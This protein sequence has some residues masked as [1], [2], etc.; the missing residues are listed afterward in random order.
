MQADDPSS[1][2]SSTFT[3]PAVALSPGTMRR[4]RRRR[5]NGRPDWSRMESLPDVMTMRPDKRDNIRIFTSQDTVVASPTTAGRN[6]F[7]PSFTK[8]DSRWKSNGGST[9]DQVP[10][11]PPTLRALISPSSRRRLRFLRNSNLM[12]QESNGSIELPFC[13]DSD[14]ITS[15]QIAKSSLNTKC[16]MKSAMEKK[17]EMNGK[18]ASNGWMY[19][20]PNLH[21]SLNAVDDSNESSGTSFTHSLT[22]LNSSSTILT[23]EASDASVPPLR[24]NRWHE[25]SSS[26]SADRSNDRP[27]L[28]P[29]SRPSISPT[30]ERFLRAQVSNDSL[31]QMPALTRYCDDD[32]DTADRS[33]CSS[34]R[35]VVSDD[36][37]T[38][39][40]SDQHSHSQFDNVSLADSPWMG[41]SN[42]SKASIATPPSP[43][44]KGE[45]TFRFET[46]N[47]NKMQSTGQDSIRKAICQP[48][49]SSYCDAETVKLV[50]INVMS[51]TPIHAESNGD[52]AL[53]PSP[54]SVLQDLYC[55]IASPLSMMS[56]QYLMS[57]PGKSR[58]KAAVSNGSTMDNESYSDVKA[59]T[60][61]KISPKKLK[62]AKRADTND[63]N[64][65][66]KLL[67][68]PAP[69]LIDYLPRTPPSSEKR[70]K[71]KVVIE[72]IA[73][74]SGVKTILEIMPSSASVTRAPKTMD[75]KEMRR[76]RGSVGVVVEKSKNDVNGA[77]FNGKQSHS[78][79][80]TTV[81]KS[82]RSGPEVVT[83]RL[84]KSPADTP[85]PA[86]SAVPVLGDTLQDSIGSMDLR[87]ASSGSLSLNDTHGQ[88]CMDRTGQAARR[89]SPYPEDD[90][91]VS[92][93][94]Q[95]RKK[96]KSRLTDRE[97]TKQRR[98][99]RG[100]T[101]TIET[102][103]KG[104]E[105]PTGLES[106]RVS[107]AESGILAHE[108]PR[109][110]KKMLNDAHSPEEKV[111]SEDAIVPRVGRQPRRGSTGTLV[112]QWEEK[113][114][115]CNVLPEREA[116][117]ANDCNYP[118]SQKQKRR[119]STGALTM[120]KMWEE[121]LLPTILPSPTN[122]PQQSLMS[123][124]RRGSAGKLAAKW[125]AVL[126]KSSISSFDPP[127]L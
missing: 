79:T 32:D 70:Q 77:P 30:Q 90:H 33:T 29:I 98:K 115:Q 85:I 24:H 18:D 91:V 1:N 100:S 50:D 43:P 27:I 63:S 116:L 67:D 117:K 83:N 19:D 25:P 108:Q 81:K 28:P 101:G 69:S 62:K 123:Q 42:H 122:S 107:D 82:V 53:N 11:T 92:P 8:T 76:R 15:S 73:K 13:D 89:L 14:K 66:K 93:V 6:K 52:G 55:P 113:A 44:T 106:H 99:R 110:L 2:S 109:R 47:V 31:A 68:F 125:K 74:G 121:Q 38:A 45:G 35:G 10:L 22:K 114:R 20:N 112:K 61:T 88:D 118:K 9:D 41:N 26:P 94:R 119:D 87:Q 127:Q 4:R 21:S 96:S 58:R 126:T 103:R 71:R 46:P 7:Y 51:E 34:S 97:T 56:K 102:R 64:P 72:T 80:K 78:Q 95:Q 37:C 57:S 16:P 40:S 104:N 54:A 120:A 23:L 105:F 59:K 86:D 84:M 65:K 12:N 5:R 3:A 75:L 39:A 124:R 111:G 17:N 49:P 60:M 48:D 36:H